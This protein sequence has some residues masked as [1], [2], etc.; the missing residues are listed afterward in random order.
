MDINS[1]VN[2]TV[3]RESGIELITSGFVVPDGEYLYWVRFEIGGD[4]LVSA[5]LSDPYDPISIASTQED[6]VS[7]ISAVTISLNGERAFGSTFSDSTVKQFSFEDAYQTDSITLEDSFNA[8]GDVRALA[9]SPEGDTLIVY[10]NDNGDLV[11]YSSDEEFSVSSMTQES[12]LSLP[13]N[14]PNSLSLSPEGDKIFISVES[15]DGAQV[16]LNSPFD[17]SAGSSQTVEQGFFTK[18]MLFSEDGDFIY[19]SSSVQPSN[20]VRRE[21]SAEYDLTTIDSYPS[22]SFPDAPKT[23]IR[24]ADQGDVLCASDASR[25]EKYVTSAYDIDNLSLDQTL[26]I[27][28]LTT[29][30]GYS[31]LCAIFADSGSRLYACADNGELYQIDLSTDYDLSTATL[32][33]EVSLASDA[34]SSFDVKADGSTFWTGVFFGGASG[35]TPAFREYSMSTPWDISTATQQYS[36]ELP[37]LNDDQII[38]QGVW[39][40]SGDS[41][42]IQRGQDV[43]YQGDA[44]TAFDAT[45]ISQADQSYSLPICVFMDSFAWDESGDTLYMISQ[46]HGDIIFGYPTGSS[47]NISDVQDKVVG[48]VPGVDSGTGPL[49]FNTPPQYR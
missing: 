32:A 35:Q 16:D 39:S 15:L 36:V 18:A 47:F 13:L 48:S 4:V 44:S 41:L 24:W 2:P 20:L 21:L 43:L 7:D 33:N 17:L 25:A 37:F 38:F 49:T 14:L 45:T 1:H 22:A 26:D 29:A 6:Q 12:A 3:G 46:D 10:D 31:V 30:S 28:T 19:Q 23:N 11:E 27:T 8:T 5:E 9:W 40:N 34:L 42:F